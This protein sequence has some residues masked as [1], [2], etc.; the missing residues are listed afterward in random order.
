MLPR[1]K[2][3]AMQ[4]RGEGGDVHFDINNRAKEVYIHS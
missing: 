1:E 3:E 4:W 2:E